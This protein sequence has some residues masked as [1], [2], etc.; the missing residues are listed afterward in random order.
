GS[1]ICSLLP[2][3]K[4]AKRWLL[5][6]MYAEFVRET[7]R[8]HFL[9]PSLDI[10]PALSQEMEKLG[11]MVKK[12]PMNECGQLTG[13]LLEETLKPRS[14]LVSISFAHPL[15]GVIQPVVELAKICEEKQVRL[16]VDASAVIGKVFFRFEDT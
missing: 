16:H 9:L 2:S 7:G 5:F 6:S 13:E 10:D 11:C 4:E 1:D 3:P 8:N 15:T 12:L 14:S